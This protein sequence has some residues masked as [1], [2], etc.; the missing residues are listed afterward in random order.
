LIRVG[1]LGAGG[2]MGRLVV[3]QVLDT[4]GLSLGAAVGRAGSPSLGSDAGLLAS[5]A[6]CGVP[7][8]ALAPGCFDAVDVV[9]DFSLPG[10]LLEAFPHLAGRALVSGTTG[11]DEAVHHALRRHSEGAA[12]V[13]ASNFSVGIQLLL[14]LVRRTASALPGAEV[15]IVE[16]HHRHKRDAPSGTALTLAD[17]VRAV[18]PGRNIGVHALRGGDVVGDHTVWFLAD[19]ER[20]ALTHLASSRAPFARGA[21]HAAAALV[22]RPAGRYAL[23][24]LLGLV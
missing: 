6:A 21:V 12:Q 10:A 1:V 5:R 13:V 11:G 2:R 14:E 3:A 8:T 16:S 20:I 22:G 17:A 9:V 19:G 23:A 24:D 15:Q 18:D 7:M 4:P